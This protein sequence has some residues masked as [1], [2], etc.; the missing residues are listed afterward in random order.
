MF[1]VLFPI[2]YGWELAQKLLS[3]V[4]K[5]TTDWKAVAILQVRMSFDQH[6]EMQRQE[7]LMLKKETQRVLLTEH[8]YTLWSIQM[9][10]FCFKR[11]KEAFF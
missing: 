10:Y 4:L 2:W 9:L 3:T 8:F 6:W 11:T 1:A 7:K 5:L